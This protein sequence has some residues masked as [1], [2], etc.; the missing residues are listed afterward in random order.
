MFPTDEFHDAI[1][2]NLDGEPLSTG[3][4]RMER[5]IAELE[6]TTTSDCE[7]ITTL[8]AITEKQS[9]MIRSRDIE[10][11]SLNQAL[12]ELHARTD[13]ERDAYW[14]AKPVPRADA[15]KVRVVRIGPN[16]FRY[17]FEVTH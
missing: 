2:V 3:V 16:T 5:R 9:E 10:I 7:R 4:K 13:E 8:R 12:E 17:E 6:R 11:E 14:A 1:V 15:G